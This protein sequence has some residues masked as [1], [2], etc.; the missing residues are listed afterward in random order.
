MAEKLYHAA[1]ATYVGL[2]VAVWRDYCSSRGGNPTRGPAPDGHDIEN[3]HARP[4][5]HPA[6]LDAWK[7]NRPG[8]GKGGG[9]KPRG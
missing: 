4:Y 6:T 2:K 8:Q 5:W 1:A 3:G 7:A 9:R